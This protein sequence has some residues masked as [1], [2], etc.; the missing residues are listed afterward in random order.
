M[1]QAYRQHVAERAALGISMRVHSTSRASTANAAGAAALAVRLPVR[2]EQNGASR[3]FAAS[4]DA[5]AY[6]IGDPAAI[7]DPAVFRRR[8]ST[9]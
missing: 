4:A 5:F 3:S 8:K 9:P 1:L 7:L 6:F 2:V